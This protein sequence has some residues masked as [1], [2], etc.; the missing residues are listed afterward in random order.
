MSGRAAAAGRRGDPAQAVPRAA[1]RVRMGV[2]ATPAAVVLGLVL[3]AAALRF[4]QLGERSLWLDEVATTDALRQPTLSAVLDWC[5]GFQLA[6]FFF[7][8][9]WETAKHG[10]DEFTLRLPSAIAGTLSV[11]YAYQLGR[12]VYGHAAGAVTAL[13][14]ATM[15]FPVWYSQEARPYGFLLLFAAAQAHYAYQAARR[16][17]ARDWVGLAA[18]TLLA[19]YTHY[20]A[21]PV[22]AAAA[23][24]IAGW[25]ALRA[26]RAARHRPGHSWRGVLVG[27][28]AAA[29]CAALVVVGYL[30]WLRTLLQFLHGDSL[31]GGYLA[32]YESR[33]FDP[34]AVALLIDT[35]GFRGLLLV[36]LV[37]GVVAVVL[38]AGRGERAAAAFLLVMVTFPVMVLAVKLH[39]GV[40]AIWGRY[41]APLFPVLAMIAAL[42]AVEI[43]RGLAA[44]CVR[45][46]PRT[47]PGRAGAVAMGAVVLVTGAQALAILIPSYAYPKDEYRQAMS[48]LVEHGSKRDVVVPA[49]DANIYL[50][51]GFPHYS[52]QFGAQIL[53]ADADYLDGYAELPGRLREP[54]VTVWVAVPNGDDPHGLR[55]ENYLATANRFTDL[56]R[57]PNPG[58][59]MTRFQGVTMVRAADTSLPAADQAILLLRW[60]AEFDVEMRAHLAPVINGLPPPS[61]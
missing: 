46:R 29:D 39:W 47:A 27:V 6:P 22:T 44:A 55:A 2:L 3:L 43:A 50:A 5:R 53:V 52:R 23:V 34:A 26:V 24:F 25:L 28:V 11:Y 15:F 19:L 37:A 17:R 21:L 12:S 54:G 7:V 30:P 16:S 49:G 41:F 51:E 45:L 59:R 58:L 60:A 14:T 61:G 20:M 48:Y 13:L 8:I 1:P 38:R 18:A 57:Y 33:S 40:F 4:Y 10:F 42:G 56:S 35:F 9:L 36:L 31:A 32:I